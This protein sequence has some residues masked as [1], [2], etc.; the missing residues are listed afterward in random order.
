MKLDKMFKE[1]HHER[2]GI[3]DRIDYL[4]SRKVVT[5][6][7]TWEA[8]SRFF[9]IQKAEIG[10]WSALGQ[11]FNSVQ[12]AKKFAR[13]YCNQKAQELAKGS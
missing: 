10:G 12:G 3:T 2:R 13:R 5:L 6:E 4:F 7:R 8:G 9:S 1:V 11:H